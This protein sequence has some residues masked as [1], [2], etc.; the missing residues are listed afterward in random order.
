MRKRTW[1]GLLGLLSPAGGGV[2]GCGSGG[3]TYDDGADGLDGKRPRPSPT[4]AVGSDAEA[5]DLASSSSEPVS[6]ME[7]PPQ[8]DGGGAGNQGCRYAYVQYQEGDEV[9]AGECTT[10]TCRA[11]EV[12]CEPTQEASCPGLPVHECPEEELPSDPIDVN[13]SYIDGYT[14]TIDVS[15]S[16]GCEEHD[17]SVCYVPGFLE[18]DPLQAIL[19]LTHD[20]HGETCEASGGGEVRFDLRELA[21]D[22][23]ETYSSAPLLITRFF[24]TLG[25]GP[26][27]CEDQQTAANYQLQHVID[28]LDLSC[29]SDE[30]CEK[31]P[32][33]TDCLQ[34]CDQVVSTRENHRLQGDAGSISS[35]DLFQREVARI[36]A[37]VC[38]DYADECGDPATRPLC[39]IDFCDPEC[40]NE[41]VPRCVDDVCTL[42]DE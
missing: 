26:L 14:L 17:Y 32:V 3:Q 22:V 11:G 41:A 25:V 4:I 39:S 19:K 8:L 7:Q 40:N 28:Q 21:S 38:G 35:R 1:V 16:A 24:G 23:A 27:T 31:I 20:A 6:S 37:G 10:C 42:T 34:T 18:S 15:H 36:N 9:P 2:L 5:P 30:Q 29:E 13:F 33:A 12:V